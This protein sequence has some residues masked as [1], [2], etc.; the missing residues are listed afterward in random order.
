MET[1]VKVTKPYSIGEPI[2]DLPEAAA[3]R[4]WGK[5]EAVWAAVR[6]LRD[7]EWLPVECQSKSVADALAN[8][9]RTHRNVR[10]AVRHRGTWVYLTRRQSPPKENR[11]AD[12]GA[13]D[14]R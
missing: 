5:Y 14:A 4:G 2:K 9:A 3:P 8:T 1:P 6:T 13:G 11:D 7:G 12:A 10:L